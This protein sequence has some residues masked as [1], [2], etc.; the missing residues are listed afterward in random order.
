[1]GTPAQSDKYR[2]LLALWRQKWAQ[3]GFNPTVL[4]ASQCR[5]PLSA[6]RA[7]RAEFDR[8]P[9]ANHRDYEWHCYRRW[10][11]IKE[12]AKSFATPILMI[13]GDVFPNPA[14]RGHP[15][16]KQPAT[17]WS[18]GFEILDVSGNP[19]AVMATADAVS[20]WV[21][22]LLD[23]M[24]ACVIDYNGTPHTSDMIVAQQSLPK[25]VRGLCAAWED[26][27]DLPMAHI[28]TDS[29]IAAGF[30]ADRKAEFIRKELR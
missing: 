16:F 29:A 8:T 2:K 26:R 10:L 18:G 20:D 25:P 7:L 5:V 14:L 24:T 30:S 22:V 27:Q 15:F 23:R 11:V 21:R 1:M 9:T 12:F 19:C 28:S 4:D 6:E 17:G 3:A 13:D